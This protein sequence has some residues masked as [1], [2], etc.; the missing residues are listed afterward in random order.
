M[1]FV[2]QV[3]TTSVQVPGGQVKFDL[4]DSSGAHVDMTL[5]V[6]GQQ[7]TTFHFNHAGSG[8]ASL[9]MTLPQG[10]YNCTLLIS[11]FTYGM[12]N[13]SYKCN[14]AV[15]GTTVVIAKGSI[16]ATPGFDHGAGDFK[17]VV[18]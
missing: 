2:V 5:A 11:V 15:N 18:P 12:L 17:I 1:S 8:N 14:G 6:Q 16:P 7:P 9:S 3:P 4:H 10:T 13:R